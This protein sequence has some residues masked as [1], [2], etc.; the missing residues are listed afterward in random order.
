M[1]NII[2]WSYDREEFHRD[3]GKSKT[4]VVYQ[5]DT[6]FSNNSFNDPT[7]RLGIR[8]VHCNVVLIIYSRDSI[9]CTTVSKSNSTLH[10]RVTHR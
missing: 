4:L 6:R 9:R 2:E 1:N 10:S 8:S 3:E 7:E 5:I